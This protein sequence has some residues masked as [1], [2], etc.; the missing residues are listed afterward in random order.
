MLLTSEIDHS[1]GESLAQQIIEMLLENQAFW[2]RANIRDLYSF[3][4][5]RA[6]G[7]KNYFVC[8]NFA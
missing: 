8:K 4:E 5:C 3:G 7:L 2:N 1:V 6:K